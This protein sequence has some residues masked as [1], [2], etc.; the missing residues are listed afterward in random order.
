VRFVGCPLTKDP[1]GGVRVNAIDALARVQARGAAAAILRALRDPK[2]Y[3]R[4]PAFAALQQ[5]TATEMAERKR[6]PNRA[7]LTDEAR[8]R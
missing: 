2:W 4:A 8:H 7:L 5:R 3:V 1:S 6:R